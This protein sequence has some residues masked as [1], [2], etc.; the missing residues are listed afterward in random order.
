MS[1]AL[2]AKFIGRKH[3]TQDRAWNL[4][5]EW[6]KRKLR[7]EIGLRQ[8]IEKKRKAKQ[9]QAE[10]EYRALKGLMG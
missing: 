6:E 3:N 4:E 1:Q 9:N 2:R 10:R 7:K 5:R 8:R